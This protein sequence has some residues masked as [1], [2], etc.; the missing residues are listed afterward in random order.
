MNTSE[1]PPSQGLRKGQATTLLVNNSGLNP[2]TEIPDPGPSQKNADEPSTSAD[3]SL[4]PRTTTSRL[5]ELLQRP[6]NAGASAAKTRVVSRKKGKA[7]EA[8]EDSA[9]S[10]PTSASPP[11]TKNK[12]IP[13]ATKSRKKSA[14]RPPG[15]FEFNLFI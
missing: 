14:A 12:Q 6:R 9:T 15:T 3:S 7:R 4:I 8:P 13:S 10:P 2:S 5:A 1:M 11:P